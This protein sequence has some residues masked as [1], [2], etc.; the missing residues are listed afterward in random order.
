MEEKLTACKDCEHCTVFLSG[1][2]GDDRCKWSDDPDR[3]STWWENGMGDFHCAAFPGLFDPIN[4]VWRPPKLPNIEAINTDGH[5]P[6][7]K[8]KEK[9]DANS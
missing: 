5:C 7:F 8:A 9:T 6:H 2:C 3:F 1:P 4:G